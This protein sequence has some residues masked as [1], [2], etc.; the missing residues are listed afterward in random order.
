MMNRFGFARIVAA[1]VV[2]T[3]L[4]AVC[5]SPAS[6][7]LGN[8]SNQS[9]V[10]I[11][12]SQDG[13]DFGSTVG[14]DFS[15]TG[16]PVSYSGGMLFGDESEGGTFGISG[17]ASASASFGRLRA[18]AQTSVT[19]NTTS[20]D[21]PPFLLP[22]FGEN[23]FG[24]PTTAGFSATAVFRDRLQYGGT[25]TSYESTYFLRM[26]GTIAGEGGFA[27]VTI[28]HGDNP[29]Q[30]FIFDDPGTYNETIVSRKFTHVNSP[31]FIRVQLQATADFF[32]DFSSEGDSASVAFGNTL[33]LV[34]V[35]LRDA[36]TG[37]LL[38]DET[39][40]TESGEGGPIARACELC[41]AVSGRLADRRPA[42]PTLTTS[43]MFRMTLK[44]KRLKPSRKSR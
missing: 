25:A 9:F 11:V 27:A 30:R 7:Q 36:D 21:E 10:D 15:D 38:V 20:G 19:D 42:S 23:E 26:T 34:G 4:S 28:E 18:A 8:L 1:S 17:S 6:A 14:G 3:G 44:L 16:A 35:E 5:A 31:Q 24:I 37:Q 41:S 40:T 33:E 32:P 13:V 43:R 29:S 22:D 12:V 2:A 39:I